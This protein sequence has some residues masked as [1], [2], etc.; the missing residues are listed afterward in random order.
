MNNIRQKTNFDLS[1]EIIKK[2]IH[3]HEQILDDVPYRMI[4]FEQPVFKLG[5]CTNDNEGMNY[6]I[7]LEINEQ[8][9]DF[10]EFQ[11]GKT[12]MFEFQE[13]EWLD[14]NADNIERIASVFINKVLVPDNVPFV[15]DY[16]FSV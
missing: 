2:R 4:E 11:I 7:F 13:E 3:S 8:G 12:G 10:Q 16:C 5:Y 14:V 1:G 9:A 6:P 15:L